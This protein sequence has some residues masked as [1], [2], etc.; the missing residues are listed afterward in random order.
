MALLTL[1][2]S[3]EETEQFVSRYRKGGIGYGEVKKRLAELTVEMFRE[4]RARREELLA[5]PSRVDQVLV[6]GAERARTVA[7]KTLAKARE[8]AGL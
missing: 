4:A 3:P 8:A 6:E 1:M 5:D 7:R 2:A